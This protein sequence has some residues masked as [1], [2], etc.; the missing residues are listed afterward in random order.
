MTDEVLLRTNR[1]AAADT[2]PQFAAQLAVA[3][4]GELLLGASEQRASRWRTS[5]TVTGACRSFRLRAIPRSSQ[6][7]DQHAAAFI[8]LDALL[9]CG[10]TAHCLSTGAAN[11]GRAVGGRCAGLQA[12]HEPGGHGGAAA[13]L[14][15]TVGSHAVS[16][17]LR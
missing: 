16:P 15:L 6:R 10:V 2:V 14:R 4:H 3:N 11:L 8:C 9:P 13:S 17:Q 5:L 12:A 7:D 1:F